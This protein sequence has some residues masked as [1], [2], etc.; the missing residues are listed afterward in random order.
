MAKRSI[1][2]QA[3]GGADEM[4][5]TGAA[6]SMRLTLVRLGRRQHLM[7]VR[8]AWEFRD[9]PAAPEHDDP[10]A[11][12][13]KLGHLARGDEDAEAFSGELA[14]PG[15]DF[16]L[17]ADVHAARRLVEQ[18]EPGTAKNFLG[19]H[20]LLLIAAGERADGNLGQRRA[21]I[22]AVDRLAG[23]A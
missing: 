20:D 1:R 11:K 12:T 23:E 19:Q 2:R 14:N 21:H 4:S 10:V 6:S 3:A 17:G 22:E 8:A 16:P 7:L 15:V 9:G 13:D 18:Q 5:R